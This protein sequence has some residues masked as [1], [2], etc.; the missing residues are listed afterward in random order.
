MN[1]QTPE[2]S[3]FSPNAQV[4]KMRFVFWLKSKGLWRMETLIFALAAVVG[5][6]GAVLQHANQAAFEKRLQEEYNVTSVIVASVRIPAG[7]ILRR[8]HL[9]SGNMLSGSRTPNMLSPREYEKLVGKPIQVALAQRDPVLLTQVALDLTDGSVASKIPEGKRLFSLVI[10]DA[11][12]Q[13]G[14]VRP[15]DFVDIVTTMDLPGRGS[16]TFTMLSRVQLTAVGRS[17]DSTNQTEGTQVSFFVT[18]KELE[19]LRHAQAHGQFSLALRNP[20]DKDTSQASKGVNLKDVF[21]SDSVYE[22]ADVPVEIN[23]GKKNEK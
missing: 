21:L 10:E 1:S 23:I 22:K 15:G 9:T 8:E 2:K 7:T 14:F 12:A 13:N 16:T 4:S 19:L 18:P 5:V 17:L 3:S 20:N 11:V 6:F